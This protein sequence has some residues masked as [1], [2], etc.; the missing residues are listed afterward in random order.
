MV[1][2]LDRLSQR[3]KCSLV[4]LREDEM[5]I[6]LYRA[7]ITNVTIGPER[8]ERILRRLFKSLAYDLGKEADEHLEYMASRLVAKRVRELAKCIVEKYRID[9]PTHVRESQHKA[10]PERIS[11]LGL[12]LMT[13]TSTISESSAVLLRE[14]P[15]S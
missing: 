5:L 14:A 7:A 4:S 1:V 13:A 11:L 3:P 8:R 9:R 10:C 12:P 6:P 15:L 2:L